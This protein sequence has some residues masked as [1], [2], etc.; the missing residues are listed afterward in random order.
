MRSLGSLECLTVITAD[1]IGNPLFASLTT[2]PLTSRKPTLFSHDSQ[3]RAD[4]TH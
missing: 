4:S 3:S 2:K 1:S